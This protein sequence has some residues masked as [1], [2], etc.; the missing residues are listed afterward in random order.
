MLDQSSENKGSEH[1]LNQIDADKL[2]IQNLS[3]EELEKITGG[4][5]SWKTLVGG[6]VLGFIGSKFLS[7]GSNGATPPPVQ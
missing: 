7:G 3:E 4:K 6:A 2:E 5:I 1:S